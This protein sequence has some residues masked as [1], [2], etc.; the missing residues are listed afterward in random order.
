MAEILLNY[1]FGAFLG[2]ISPIFVLRSWQ[3]T[4]MIF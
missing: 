3:H 2:A 4:G 1:T